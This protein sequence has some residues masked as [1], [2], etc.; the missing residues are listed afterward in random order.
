MATKSAIHF[1]LLHIPITMQK[2]N[3]ST[4]ISFN[5]LSKETNER[6]KYVKT[7]PHC[8]KELTNDDI[9][10]GYEFEKGKYVTF[11]NTELENLKSKTDKM[12]QILHFAKISDIDSIYFDKN[13]YTIPQ[14]GGEK[15]FDL[16][17][18]AMLSKKVVAIAKTVLVSKEVLLALQATNE[19]I[20]AKVLYYH[21]EIASYPAYHQTPV[22]KN[23]L[24]LAKSL[25]DQSM[26][27]FTIE[28]YTD[29]YQEKLRLAI[30]AKIQ[31]QSIVSPDVDTAAPTNSALSLL[32][33][34]TQTLALKNEETPS[35]PS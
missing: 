28:Q 18:Q 23:E 25:I 22:D 19:G 15:A 8:T 14:A 2:A 1:G 9:I 6:I 26:Q 24:K 34:L 31:G 32:D 5:Q 29:T 33:Q 20:I 4:S 12:I 16:L 17:R 35:S 21:Q 30:Q 3:L 13:Y 11:D 7:C 27:D 10:K